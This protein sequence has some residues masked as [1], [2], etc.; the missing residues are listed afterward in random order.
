ME[1]CL[2]CVVFS[3]IEFVQLNSEAASKMWLLASA[4]TVDFPWI[5]RATGP[6]PAFSVNIKCV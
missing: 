5:T 3:V 1:P 6:G 4:T 2:T